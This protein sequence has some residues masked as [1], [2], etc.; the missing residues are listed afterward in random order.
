MVMMGEQPV[1]FEVY[2]D[3]QIF[4]DSKLIIIYNLYSVKIER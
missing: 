4:L 2:R 3:Q 1:I